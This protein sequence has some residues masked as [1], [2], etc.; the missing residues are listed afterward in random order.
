MTVTS[1]VYMYNVMSL[2]LSQQERPLGGGQIS[3]DEQQSWY[4]QY[5]WLWEDSIALG[6]FVSFSVVVDYFEFL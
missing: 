6:L 4:E 1:Y 3:T 5:G 2:L